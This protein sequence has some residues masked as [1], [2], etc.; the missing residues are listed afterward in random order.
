VGKS[1]CADSDIPFEER[2]YNAEIDGAGDR[3]EQDHLRI[4]EVG[5]SIVVGKKVPEQFTAPQRPMLG[6]LGSGHKSRRPGAG[7]GRR[8]EPCDAKLPFTIRTLATKRCDTHN[9][10]VLRGKHEH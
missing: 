4:A 9:L 10:D 5:N 8:V 2:G 6:L 3:A 1:I 7:L